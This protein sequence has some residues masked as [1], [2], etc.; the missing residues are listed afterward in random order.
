MRMFDAPPVSAG[1]RDCERSKMIIATDYAVIIAPSGATCDV[2]NTTCSGEPCEATLVDGRERY[3]HVDL[4]TCL[5]RWIRE[6][7]DGERP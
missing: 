5:V 1:V 6:D 3:S 4:G 2:C 7:M